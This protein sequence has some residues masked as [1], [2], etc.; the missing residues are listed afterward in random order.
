MGDRL[1]PGG[2]LVIIKDNQLALR[3]ECEQAFCE[4]EG[5]SPLPKTALAG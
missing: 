5:F 1:E 4:P 3:R 2:Y